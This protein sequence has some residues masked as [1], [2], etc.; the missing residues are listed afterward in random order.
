MGRVSMYGTDCKKSRSNGKRKSYL[1]RHSIVA[2]KMDKM[3]PC[4]HFIYPAHVIAAINKNISITKRK[5]I[6]QTIKDTIRNLESEGLI[7][8]GTGADRWMSSGYL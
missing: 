4:K 5:N 3:P 2:I 6:C 1:A 7:K 8:R